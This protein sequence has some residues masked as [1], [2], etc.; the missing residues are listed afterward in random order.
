MA[1]FKEAAY[2]VLEEK[3]Q[4]L[5]TEQ[6]VALAKERGYLATEGATPERTMDAILGRDIKEGKSLFDKTGKREFQINPALKPAERKVLGKL[7]VEEES[8]KALDIALPDGGQGMSSVGKGAIGEARIVELI[9]L[10]SEALPLACYR[11][12]T[13]DEGVDIVVKEKRRCD[14]MFLQVK[15]CWVGDDGNKRMVATIKADSL[16]KKMDKKL[17][18]VFCLFSKSKGVEKLWFVPA[19]DLR[20]KAEKTKRGLFTFTPGE[21]KD[22]EWRDGRKGKWNDY[23][24]PDNKGALAEKIIEHIA[25]CR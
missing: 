12:F 23:L 4:P 13:D 25:K 2:K 21:M 3:N 6:I 8:R 1:T 15:G 7:L 9:S 20:E 22:G 24:L 17:A 10:H 18:I 11:P 19:P 14:T 5:R 16:H